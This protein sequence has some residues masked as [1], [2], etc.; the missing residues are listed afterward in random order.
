MEICNLFNYP[1]EETVVS[2]PTNDDIT[3]AIIEQFQPSP[4]PADDDDDDNS[5]ELPVVNR[6]KHQK[7]FPSSS[8]SGHSKR[9]AILLLLT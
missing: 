8:S 5:Q 6:G 1:N 3:E 2:V 9:T 4:L 7:C